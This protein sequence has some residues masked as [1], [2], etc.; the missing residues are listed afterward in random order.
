M[1]TL[2]LKIVNM[3]ITAS[4][5]ILAV[6]L[7]RLLLKKA[8]KWIRCLLWGFVA[9]RLVCPFS[10]E[11]ELSLIPSREMIPMNVAVQQKPVIHSGIPSAHEA[12]NPIMAQSAAPVSES[13]LHSLQ[14]LLPFAATVWVVGIFI[15]LA[16]ALF[17]YLKLKKTV[18]VCVPAGKGMVVSD[19]VKAPFILGVLK[20]IIYLPSSMDGETR[21][22]AICHEQAHVKRHDHW[23]K[24]FG[25]LLL[26]VY[27][28]N[29]LCWVAYCLLCRDIEI[30]C[31]EKVIRDMD[32][33]EMAA[34]SQALLDCS[35]PG[36]K[37]A[38]CPL[39]FGEVGV[40]E[41]VKAVLSYKKPAFWII[42][43][44]VLVCAGMAVSLLTD[45]SSNKNLSHKLAIS[46]DMAIAG[47]FQSN[48]KDY[49]KDGSFGTLAYD[50][51]GISKK[52]NQTTVYAQVLYEEYSAYGFDVRLES[53]SFSPTAITFDTSNDDT[54]IASYPVIEYWEP[55]DGKL[56]AEDIRAKFPLLIRRKA[57]DYKGEEVLHEKCVQAAR[58]HFNRGWINLAEAPE[59]SFSWT[60]GTTVE[61]DSLK[62][63]Y[64]EYYDLDTS[65]GLEVYVWQMAPGSYSFGL[66]PG[67]DR[68]KT[69]QEIWNLRGTSAE[70]MKSILS[71]YNV[72]EKDVFII[73]CQKPISSYIGEYW[74]RQEDEDAESMKVRRQAYVESIRDMLFGA[75]Q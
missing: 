31:D 10:L 23:W 65:K 1:S 8:P 40:K 54:D 60:S 53:G 57:V 47:H 74:V 21:E 13:S 6:I 46:M 27:W 5:L 38:V 2:F 35:F 16:Y 73:P 49:H 24:P 11:S 26:S 3:S 20:P 33:F 18:S 37:I 55:R 7:V 59:G 58:D 15:M 42:L 70:E 30:A 67:T 62:E 9:I 64:P 14:S 52:G 48:H 61:F 45:P 12:V 4:W 32:R 36:K 17:S 68:E 19:E 50:V 22:Y 28:F 66:L 51:L 56:F 72:E 39:A 75:A 69:D 44:A 41:R 43:V 71:G 63:K 25:F 34:Y 29:P